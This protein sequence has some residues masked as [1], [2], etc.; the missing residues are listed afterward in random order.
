[1]GLVALLVS[2]AYAGEWR[3][4]IDLSARGIYSDNIGLGESSEDSDFVTDITPR[5]VVTGEGRRLTMQFIYSIQNLV[6]ARD[7]DRNTTNHRLNTSLNSE[8]IQNFLFF[9]ATGRVSQELFDSRAGVS[10]DRISG[11]GNV[12]DVYGYSLS[13]SVTPRLGDILQANVRY[14]YD[15]VE[16]GADS[17]GFG[18]SEGNAVQ[19][20]V[21]NGPATANLYWN[22]S[23]S[24]RETEYDEGDT[25]DTELAQ[26]QIG[27]RIGNK[28][29]FF[30][31]GTREE[32][33]FTG[34]RGNTRPE[35]SFYG[36]GITWQPNANLQVSVGY[37]ER[38]DPRP[39]EDERFASGSVFWTP[40]QRTE[41]SGSWGQRFFG[42]TY[43]FRF[44]HRMRRSSWQVS[45]TE[46]VSDFRQQFL[47]QQLI[48]ALICPVNVI[49]FQNCRLFDQNDPPGPGE[50]VVGIVD[51][52][53]SQSDNTFISRVASASWSIKGGKNV[54]TLGASNQQREFVSD[55]VEEEDF[56]ASLNW[57]YQLAPQTTSVAAVRHALRE[58]DAGDESEEIIV[59]WDLRKR[60]SPKTNVSLEV[61]HTDRE[62]DRAGNDYTENRVIISLQH[63]F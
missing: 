50:E 46:G 3:S 18:D 28:W 54:I 61:S 10:R 52:V 55:G 37:N 20:T 32:N 62:A 6:Y 14:T 34:S 2:P 44:S 9:D 22:L 45:Y 24:S 53:P 41:L 26:G 4:E 47:T 43:N 35:D 39:D 29:S 49:D 23:Y 16:S 40:S 25:T 13:P 8:L 57:S 17:G 63:T 56:S 21:V 15:Y 27:Y 19:A 7:S 51:L 58:F 5:V 59:S 30:A 1:M 42:D 60:L 12:G 31:S 38:T 33:T 36:G 11:A 48:G